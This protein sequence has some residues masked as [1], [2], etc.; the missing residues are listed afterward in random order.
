MIRLGAF[1]GIL[2][3]L[4]C[5]TAVL[6]ATSSG[7]FRLIDLTDEFANFHAESNKL[8]AASRGRAFNDRFSL[9][10]PD[11]YR[12]NS[13][14][15]DPKY[16]DRLMKSLSNFPEQRKGIGKVS[17]RFLSSFLPA[18]RSFEEAFEPITNL[19]PIYLLH[20]L[21]QLM[22]R[23]GRLGESAIFSLAPISSPKYTLMRM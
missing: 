8:D 23:L 22:V 9:V 16:N 7:S 5:G 3:R 6:A 15:Y 20:S 1:A 13:N 11:L 18:R 19:P 12:S 17:R 2:Y 14:A 4:L 10:L 21:G